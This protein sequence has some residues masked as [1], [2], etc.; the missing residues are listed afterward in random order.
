MFPPVKRVFLSSVGRGLEKHRQAVSKAIGYL[1][2]YKCVRMEDFGARNRSSIDFCCE[3]VR[4]CSIFVGILGPAYG[5]CTRS[6]SRSFSELEYD[7]ADDADIP[8]LMFLTDDRF[9]GAKCPVER[10]WKQ[11]KQSAFRRR[12]T[13][14]R[15][16]RYFGSSMDLAIQVVVALYNQERSK[17]SKEPGR[18]TAPENHS[19]E[20]RPEATSIKE[21]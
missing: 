1:D 21:N 4:D 8:R 7:A 11:R 18:S 16:V 19:D 10:K 3:T 6:S 5:N 12:V 15:Q 13:N 20:K 14:Q 17:E 9:R 2:G